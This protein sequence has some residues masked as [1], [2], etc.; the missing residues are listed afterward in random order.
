[1]DLLL[2][3]DRADSRVPSLFAGGVEGHHEDP[4]GHDV[5]GVRVA[6]VPAVVPHG[7]NARG[8]PPEG[9]VALEPRAEDGSAGRRSWLK[10]ARPGASLS[11]VAAQSLSGDL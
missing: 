2:L 6:A 5:T 3:P 1:M 8:C 9:S 7:L 10:W 4:V 11:A